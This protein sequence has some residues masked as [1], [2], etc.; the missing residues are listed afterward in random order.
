[1]IPQ[2]KKQTYEE[3]RRQADE[4]VLNCAGN[5]F[6]E[7]LMIPPYT[8]DKL[9]PRVCAFIVHPNECKGRWNT[10]AV[11]AVAINENGELLDSRTYNTIM[12]PWAAELNA[13]EYNDDYQSLKQLITKYRV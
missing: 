10:K 2:I 13:V 7:I 11:T 4:Y 12:M 8:V 1:M 3:L 9:P 5:T 6:K